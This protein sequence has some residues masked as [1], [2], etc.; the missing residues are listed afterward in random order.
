MFVFHQPHPSTSNPGQSFVG[1]IKI[2]GGKFTIRNKSL[3]FSLKPSSSICTQSECCSTCLI[4][5]SDCSIL[6]GT[7]LFSNKSTPKTETLKCGKTPSSR[8]QEAMPRKRNNARSTGSRTA[9]KDKRPK[10]AGGILGFKQQN[11]GKVKF[12]GSK[13]KSNERKYKKNKKKQKITPN[14][15]MKS[16]EETQKKTHTVTGKNQLKKKQDSETK[17]EEERQKNT[18]T[19]TG[20]NQLKK[21]QDLEMKSEE[22][23]QKITH[24]VTGKNQLKKE[25]DSETKLEEETQKNTHTVT[26]KNQLKKEQDLDKT[27][28][29]KDNNFGTTLVPNQPDGILKQVQK[30]Q[31]KTQHNRKRQSQTTQQNKLKKLRL[32]IKSQLEEIKQAREKYKQTKDQSDKARLSALVQSVS[33]R[34]KSWRQKE[35]CNGGPEK[36]KVI[37]HKSK[38]IK[39]VSIR[40]IINLTHRASKGGDVQKSMATWGGV[41]T[42]IN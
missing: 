5:K 4:P 34:V 36:V 12:K 38:K 30:T 15:G 23:T 21:E 6:H 16:E 31:E 22:D 28:L 35:I 1:E 26:R 40:K 9:T 13:K 14:L 2:P 7:K 20:K 32:V 39:T 27:I 24:T 10:T 19:V 17:L 29:H 25:Q 11:T 18:H 41:Y 42:K 8:Q 37:T 33:D 3:S